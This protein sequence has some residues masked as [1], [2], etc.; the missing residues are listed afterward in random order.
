MRNMEKL[1]NGIINAFKGLVDWISNKT[2]KEGWKKTIGSIVLAMAIIAFLS[3]YINNSFPKML[4]KHTREQEEVHKQRFMETQKTYTNIKQYL[5]LHRAEIGANYI[6]YLNYHN[7]VENIESSH[8]FCKFDMAIEVLSDSV[9]YIGIDEMQNENLYKYDLLLSDK[10]IKTKISSFS[11]DEVYIID[12]NLH[13]VLV[14]EYSQ[15]LVFYNIEH[16]GTTIGTLIFLFKD[17]EVDYRSITNCSRK[18]EN[19]INSSNNRNNKKP[20][21]TN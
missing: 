11:A 21:N 17:N 16:K 18:V 10:V 7:I 14:N 20:H 4:N 13:H 1:F 12:R 2:S 19:I 9:P 6:L 3:F 15:F 5:K 8:K